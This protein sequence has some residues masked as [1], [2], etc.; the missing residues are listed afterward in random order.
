V[1]RLTPRIKRRTNFEY[2]AAQARTVESYLAL[3]RL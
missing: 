1:M 2:G 3:G